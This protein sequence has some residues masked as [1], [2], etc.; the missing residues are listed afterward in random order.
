MNSKSKNE[1]IL[2]VVTDIFLFLALFILPWWLFVIILFL[3]LFWYKTFYEF[4]FFAIM[5]DV[6]FSAPYMSFLHAHMYTIIS[7]VIFYIIEM[8]KSRIL[9]YR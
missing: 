9:A 6:L 1:K 2:R 8:I 5:L 7:I 3:F 4:I